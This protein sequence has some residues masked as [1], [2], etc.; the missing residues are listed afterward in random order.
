MPISLSIT[1]GILVIK[2]DKLR[3]L[4]L[5]ITTLLL[6]ICFTAQ[7]QVGMDI[8]GDSPGEFSGFRNA[9]NNDGTV[10][11]TGSG[12][13]ENMTGRVR[14]FQF[15]GNDWIQIGQDILGE[16]TGDLCR[17]ADLNGT[18]NLIAIGASD[19]DDN[20]M[21]TG[22]VRIFELNGNI[23][24]QIGQEI[25]GDAPGDVSGSS[26]ALSDNGSVIA[27]GAVGNDDNGANSG[28]VR[29]FE[30]DGNN[31][32]QKGQDLN[33]MSALDYF[34][35]S[36][37]INNNGNRIVVG[38]NGSDAAGLDA[39]Q[40]FIYEYNGSSWVQLGSEINGEESGDLSGNQVSMNGTGNIVAIGAPSHNGA[41]G[42]AGQVRIFMFDGND[43]TQLGQEIEG[44]GSND[45]IGDLDNV[46]L[47]H[48]GHVVAIGSNWNNGNG[49]DSG[50]VRIFQFVQNQWTQVGSDIDG[51]WSGDGSG[52]L[53][54]SGDGTTVS[55]G[56]TRNDDGGNDA[57]HVRVFDF[58]NLL[59]I[60][61]HRNYSVISIYPNPANDRIL[62]ENKYGIEIETVKFFDAIGRK[63]LE[64]KDV[65]YAISVSELNSGIYIVQIVTNGGIVTE[66]LIKE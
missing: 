36:V 55:I 47:S 41:A 15:S 61:V 11:A 28:Q 50:H 27:I 30:Y 21:D 17:V 6:P 48:S 57:G 31:W 33:G 58:S 56:A 8:D 64:R 53:E 26:I 9:I 59:N 16:S 19:H 38:A 43:W 13:Y 39:G 37:A 5:L 2:V 51:E 49:S 54:L 45:S 7:T 62:L 65:D 34:G 35:R 42:N 22:H 10:V 40:T 23:W 18:G 20:G 29:V 60:G 44:E 4:V 14:V 63:V 52:H 24:S 32:I 3:G 25:V 12:F 66:K 1:K 46:G